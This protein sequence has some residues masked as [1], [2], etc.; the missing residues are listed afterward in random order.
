MHVSQ[1]TGVASAGVTITWEEMALVEGPDEVDPD[2]FKRY[3]RNR[4]FHTDWKEAQSAFTHLVEW[5][6]KRFTVTEEGTG[7]ADHGSVCEGSW[8]HTCNHVQWFKGSMKLNG[9]YVK[10]VWLPNQHRWKRVY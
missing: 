8:E 3:T 5:N 2:R 1:A 10:Y 4:Y 9:V 7:W 6:R